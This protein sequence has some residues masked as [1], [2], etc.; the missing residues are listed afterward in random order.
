[1]RE[2]FSEKAFLWIDLLKQDEYF[3]L[4]QRPDSLLERLT[5]AESNSLVVIDEVQR[6]PELLNLVHLLIEERGI[7]FILSGSSSRKLKRGDANLLAGRALY[8]ELFPLTSVELG[9][10]FNL[11]SALEWG[12]LPSL[13]CLKEKQEKIE[14][15]E[16]YVEVYLRE[17]V[18]AEQLVRKLPPFRRFLDIA[19]QMNTKIINYSK[20]G[21]ETGVSSDTIKQY[22]S[23]LEETH[24]GFLL[25]AYHR[26]IRKQQTQ[27]P[28]FYFFDCGLPRAI[29]R[30]NE[31]PL[32]ESTSLFG[33]TFE[34]FVVL[35]LVRLNSYFRKRARFSYLRTKDNAEID[36]IVDLP[37]QEVVLVEIKS[38][39]N[40]SPI[41]LTTVRDFHLELGSRAYCLSRDPVEKVING[42]K[43]VPWSKGIQEIL[44]TVD[45]GKA[46]S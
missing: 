11:R 23:I 39:N 34:Q 42:V 10:D 15:L 17:E 5:A 44:E 37:G 36:L 14:Y 19:A 27:A 12:T 29:L 13:A 32:N 28:K 33:D 22:F 26:S 45:H 40:I 31:A 3:A 41:D 24:L 2:R 9:Q 30:T 18:V 35:E 6:V 46:G 38:S 4:S 8:Y 7:K 21:R 1:M 16:S 43:V 20:I 25:P